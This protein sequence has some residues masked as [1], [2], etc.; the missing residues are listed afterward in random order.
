MEDR[1]AVYLFGDQTDDARF[2]LRTL[3]HSERDPILETFLRESYLRLRAEVLRYNTS[4]QQFASLLELLEVEFQGSCRVGVEHALTSICQFGVFFKECHRASGQYPTAGNTYLIGLCTG[5]LTA[6]A[7]SCCRSLSELLPVAVEV[8]VL[9]FYIGEVAWQ[10]GNSFS[11]RNEAENTSWAVAMPTLDYDLAEEY[12]EAWVS[13][14]RAKSSRPYIGMKSPRGVTICGPPQVLQQVKKSQEFKTMMSVTLPIYAPYHAKHLYSPVVLESLLSRIRGIDADNF[15]QSVPIISSHSTGSAAGSTLA[16]AISTALTAVLLERMDIGNLVNS[17][18]SQLRDRSTALLIPIASGAAPMLQ[19]ALKLETNIQIKIAN[20]KTQP[21]SD[22]IQNNSRARIAIV[23]SSGRFPGGADSNAAFWDLLVQG[24]DVH[25][26]VPASRWNAS[27]HVDQ[28]EHPRKNTSATPFGCWLEEAGLFDA[29]FFGMSPREAEQVDPAQRLALMVAYE[30]LEEGGIVSG[31]RSSQPSR[32]GVAF[33]VTS[34]DWMETNSAQNIDTYMIPGGNRAFIPGRINYAFK[35]SGPSYAVDT[36][37]SSS[38]A[39]IDV[40]CGVLWRQEADTMIAG[41]ANIIT[42]PDFTAGLD[43][44]HFLSRTGN[45]KTFDDGADGYCR[46]EGVGVVILKRLEDAIKDGDPIKGVI[47]DIRTNHSAEAESITRPHPKAQS[48]L[49]TRVL[50]GLRP[51]NISYVEMHGTGT[52]VGDAG[53]M[54]SVLSTIAPNHGPRRRT[55]GEVVHVGSAKPNFGH[56]EAVAG[57]TS[58]IKLLVMMQ[59]DKIPPHVGINT[60][61]NRKFPE[62]LAERGVRIASAPTPWK[63]NGLQPRYALLNNFSA[64]GGNTSLLLED[65]PFKGIQTKGEDPRPI[66]PIAIT[67]KTSS[68]LHANTRSLLNFTQQSTNLDLASLSYTTTS[69]R[70]HHSYRLALSASSITE[71]ISKLSAIVQVP[72]KT[73]PSSLPHSISFVFTGQGGHYIGTGRE[74]YHTN[75]SFRSDI[76]RYDELVKLLGFAPFLPIIRDSTGDLLNFTAEETQL[77]HTSLQ[78]ALSRLWISFGAIPSN[79][80][81]HSLGHYA[82]LNAA[83]ILSEADTLYAVGA[84]VRL[85]QENCQP[86]THRMLAIRASKEDV[87]RFL[88]DTGIDVACINGPQDIVLSGKRADIDMLGEALR[89]HQIRTT[90]LDTQYAFHSSQVDCI[91]EK[92]EM[93]IQAINFGTARIPILCPLAGNMVHKGET[94]GPRHLVDHFRGTVDVVSAIEAAKDEGIIN[95][96]TRF[97]EIGHNAT[98]TSILKATLGSSCHAKHSLK[99]NLNN[100]TSLTETTTWLY[101]AGV[102][103]RWDEFHRDFSR[104][105]SVIPLPRYNWDLKN[106]WIQ[107]VNDWSLRKGEPPQV[108][109]FSDRPSLLSRTIHVVL[110]EEVERLPAT[111]ELRSDLNR[112]ELHSIAQGHKVNGIPLCTPSIYADIALTVGR[113]LQKIV[114]DS[115]SEKEISIRNMA[116]SK[117]LVALP[118]GPQWLQTLV[119]VDERLS[120]ACEFSTVDDRGA[121]IIKHADCEIGFTS[122]TSTEAM[123]DVVL[124]TTEA[125]KTVRTGLA[126]GIAYRFN[127]TMIYRMVATLAEFD[128]AYRGLEEIVLDSKAMSASSVVNFSSMPEEGFPQPFSASPAYIDCFTQVAGFI[129]N[130]NDASDLAKE[131]FVN[132]G[133]GSLTLYAELEKEAVHECYVKMH[134]YE[135]SIWKGTLT[136]LREGTL[137]AIFEDLTLQGVPHRLLHHVLSTAQKA[138]E[139]GSAIPPSPTTAAIPERVLPSLTL[140]PTITDTK[141]ADLTSRLDTLLEIVSSESGIK[142]SELHD[143]TELV[144]LGIDSLLSLLIASRLKDD[145]D[146]DLGSGITLFD[147]YRTLGELKAAYAKGKGIL[148]YFSSTSS[149]SKSKEASVIGTPAS[150]TSDTCP[151]ATIP[152][153]PETS[154]ARPVTSLVLQKASVENSTTLFLFPDGSGS[155]ASYISLPPL[156]SRITIIAL[157]SPYRHDAEA[158]TCTLPSLIASYIAEIKRRQPTGSYT[159]GG[160]SSG[161]IFAF[162]AAQML[163]DNGAGVR[164]LL[165]LDSPPLKVGGGL[166]R[167]P[168]RFYEH[169]RDVGVFEQIAGGVEDG[170]KGNDAGKGN[171]HPEWLVPH[172][173]ATVNLLAGYRAEPLRVPHG[174]EKPRVAVCWA[175]KCALDGVRYG[176]FEVEAND[177]ESVKFLVEE[178]KDYGAGGWA[179]LFPGISCR[180]ETLQGWDH[181]NM[182]VGE[183]AKELGSFIERSI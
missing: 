41:G 27:T 65:A 117:A 11:C 168:E 1:T 21:V 80:M 161:G 17:L 103:I 57:V 109:S 164:D 9:S 86:G 160:W 113:Y 56:G 106:Y 120:T 38:L 55:K 69:R 10:A 138:Q 118:K 102:N 127:T 44:G 181:F 24:R 63:R 141:A 136:V 64:A 100:W 83:G 88:P 75:T 70:L 142:K 101:K 42:N 152:T 73:Q 126:S 14:H 178:R 128:P 40:A 131:C 121:V 81:G 47:V 147:S 145:L 84:R 49:F 139:K 68:A 53:E 169:C 43:R 135:G 119:R 23:G 155:A 151:S 74:L 125:I 159:L 78:M 34:N 154:S 76:D 174:I 150:S 52:Q 180:V 122:H 97:V 58:L 37:C 12:I 149:S 87:E 46:G 19:Q 39:A 59:N 62:D 93:A 95:D 104:N 32:V 172:F 30:A 170:A 26:V 6:A 92:F 129:M 156:S 20:L 91:L 175:G 130:A 50:N 2:P 67:A 143:D 54:S 7:V 71:L 116:I 110:K 5:T 36:A 33:G 8:A 177:P 137:V 176:M 132:H 29:R 48:D 66:F 108:V 115:F 96:H 13:K 85:L 31:A 28:S 163:L 82:A 89:E 167:L 144:D 3:L 133:W 25:K 4:T 173:K 179:E 15:S 51:G 183:G 22:Y 61:I 158:M 182:M 105:L 171:K 162:C 124:Q 153:V 98:V 35:F 60:R 94:L 112:P 45:C 99:R 165:L 79:V 140:Q 134:K 166:G 72:P 90:V 123:K 114:P 77:A 16:E 157:I 18:G 107:Y 146:F 148:P 111:I